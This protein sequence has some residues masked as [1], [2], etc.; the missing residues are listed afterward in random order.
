[1]EHVVN[2]LMHEAWVAG[3]THEK[4][5][6]LGKP[7]AKPMTLD[8]VHGQIDARD[9]WLRVPHSVSEWRPYSEMPPELLSQLLRRAAS[10]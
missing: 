6:L 2:E 5:F 3:A 1:M 7:D 10:S 8:L 4:T 9:H